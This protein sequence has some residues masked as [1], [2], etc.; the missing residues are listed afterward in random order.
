MLN[1]ADRGFF[2]MDRFLRFSAAGA[3]LA[4]RV[5]S[6]AKSVPFKTI[7][8]LPD[9]SELVMLHESG[10]MR[11]RRRRESGNPRAER[12]PDTTARLVTFTVTARTR[13]GHAKTTQI[14][15]LTTLLDHEAY[16]AREI[17]ALYA[18][19]WQIEVGHRWHQ[20]SCFAFSRLRSFLAGFLVSRR[21]ARTAVVAGRACPAFAQFS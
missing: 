9:G 20:S 19:R 10:G 4:W 6:S 8:E 5:K 12:L 3:H 17:A 2:S 15:V 7:R 11:T 21:E 1:L 14:R 13:S 16:P 18:E